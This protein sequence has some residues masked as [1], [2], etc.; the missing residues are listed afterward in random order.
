[1]NLINAISVLN[2]VNFDD[3]LIKVIGLEIVKDSIKQMNIMQIYQ[4]GIDSTGKKIEAKNTPWKVY[5]PSY[6]KYKTALGKY[7]GYVDLSLSGRFLETLNI[8]LVQN[9]LLI[10]FAGY[11]ADGGNLAEKLIQ[12]YGDE[13]E[14][15]T[16]ENLK[17]VCDEIILPN[18]QAEFYEVLKTAF[19]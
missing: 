13:I 10:E 11:I 7:Q 14:G 6:E 17:K 12:K 2:N 19:A 9:G 4:Q 1:M 18:L 16:N 8:A 15:L 5:A 3:I